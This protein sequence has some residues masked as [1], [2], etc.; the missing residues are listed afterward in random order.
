MLG[1]PMLVSLI[2][3]PLLIRLALRYG[4]FVDTPSDRR[5]HSNPTPRCGGIGIYLGIQSAFL[6]YGYFASLGITH[7][8]TLGL[9][10]WSSFL[11]PSTL[12]FAIGLI[13]DLRG[14]R[15]VVKLLGQIA[16]AGIAFYFGISVDHLAGYSL[17]LY[18]DLLL[19]VLWFLVIVNSF[20]LIDGLDGLASGL[21]LTSLF[22]IGAVAFYLRLPGD[23]LIILGFFG[24]IAGFLY[25]NFHPASIFMGDSGSHLIGF[26]IAALALSTNTKSSTLLTLGVCVLAVG[27]PVFDV[28]LA[29]WRRLNRR[30][31]AAEGEGGVTKADTDHLHHRLLA[32]EGDQR[33]VAVWLYLANLLVVC[34]GLYVLFNKE[35]A[36][37]VVLL[38]TLVMSYTILRCTA[39]IELWD[40]AR[41]LTKQIKTPRW[42]IISLTMLP[43]ADILMLAFAFSCS[44]FLVYPAL[45]L[46]ALKELW[47]AS[48]GI[49][50]LL[51]FLFLILAGSYRHVWSRAGVEAYLSTAFAIIAAGGIQLALNIARDVADVPT[52]TIF[53]HELVFVSSSVFGIIFIRTLP[54]LL[55]E[56]VSLL[57]T[58]ESK[59]GELERVIV[60]GAG[61]D[62]ISYLIKELHSRAD[63]L[64]EVVGFVDEDRLLRGRYV[65]GLPVFGTLDELPRIITTLNIDHIIICSDITQLQ[66]ERIEELAQ[67]TD[68][69]LSRWIAEELSLVA[70]GFSEV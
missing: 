70:P 28:A 33:R 59:D 43:V 42:P 3:T 64:R 41:I 17:P 68:R 20:N 34:L 23:T 29:V 13:D 7:K 57:R 50:V 61:Y 11:L 16:A 30:I 69:S 35:A 45:S 60:L 10:W 63:S 52:R 22:A 6:V 25:F 65:Q 18:F 27:V 47:F 32:Q 46:N 67:D 66:L 44:L 55:R 56:A 62:G 37:G 38:V 4:I 2:A 21:A 14:M 5:I 54:S 26:S 58:V 31:L 15:A 8:G 12:I 49:R 48:L 51:P 39:Q 9:Q 53:L 36:L 19:T 40:T 1:V 24:A